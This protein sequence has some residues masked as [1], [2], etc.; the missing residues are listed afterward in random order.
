MGSAPLNAGV[1]EGRRHRAAGWTTIL[2]GLA[3]I[4]AGIT[5]VVLP[6]FGILLQ[7][8]ILAGGLLV[9]GIAKVSV[10][11]KGRHLTPLL[12]RFGLGMGAVTIAIAVAVLISVLILLLGEAFPALRRDFPDL[13]E[14]AELLSVG[15]IL[16]ILAATLVLFGIDRLL[17]GYA[18]LLPPG[19]RVALVIIGSASIALAA[20]TLVFPT[21]GEVLII[22]ILVFALSAMGLSAILVG[23]HTIRT[24]PIG[25]VAPGLK[26]VGK[27]TDLKEGWEPEA[28]LH[29]FVVGSRREIIE[30]LRALSRR[31][32]LKFQ[33]GALRA[34][35]RENLDE[36]PLF[37]RLR[38]YADQFGDLQVREGGEWGAIEEQFKAFSSTT[39]RK[40]FQWLRPMGALT[41]K[42]HVTRIAYVLRKTPIDLVASGGSAFSI[43]GSLTRLK[44]AVARSKM[45]VTEEFLKRVSDEFGLFRGSLP[46]KGAY[47]LHITGL[48]VDVDSDKLGDIYDD[49]ATV[50]WDFGATHTEVGALDP[51]D[52]LM[53]GT[54]NFLLGPAVLFQHFFDEGRPV[55]LIHKGR[56]VRAEWRGR[57][58]VT[59]LSDAIDVE[60]AFKRGVVTLPNPVVREVREDSSLAPDSLILSATTSAEVDPADR[61]KEEAWDLV[62]ISAEGLRDKGFE[63]IDW[64]LV[65]AMMQADYTSAKSE[66]V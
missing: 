59:H 24:R 50:L 44:K 21:F 28:R 2:L 15:L 56:A 30:S 22:L 1:V 9:V 58:M 37:E 4:A 60:L 64:E 45:P 34:A 53:S 10:S 54:T 29:C 26:K 48:P 6:A 40:K 46:A 14:L 61:G 57:R 19:Q 8:L 41:S 3:A 38:A 55:G 17:E 11:Q 47:I 35:R 36:E 32:S 27:L 18:A 20:L 13:F 39:S 31:A 12:R 42:V 62:G 25:G 23:V 33:Q 7:I 63:R 43:G 16:F 66:A 52:H 5:I 65:R 49:D 51:A